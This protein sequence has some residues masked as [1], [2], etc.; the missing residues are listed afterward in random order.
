MYLIYIQ[1]SNSAFY[2][3]WSLPSSEPNVIID[4]APIPTNWTK[5]HVK[6]YFLG[7]LEDKK[8]YDG[9]F[10]FWPQIFTVQHGY[11]RLR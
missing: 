7:K 2:G 11:G 3:N 4:E 10:I 6:P 1:A 9:F 5:P 8:M